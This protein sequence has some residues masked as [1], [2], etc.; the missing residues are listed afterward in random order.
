MITDEGFCSSP[1]TVYALSESVI[2]GRY[3]VIDEDQEFFGQVGYF[4]F[5]NNWK[6]WLCVWSIRKIWQSETDFNLLFVLLESSQNHLSGDK[7]FCPET[8]QANKVIKKNTGQKGPV[9]W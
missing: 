8:H 6:H 5:I 9:K 4:L 3:F 7:E 1:L 2:L